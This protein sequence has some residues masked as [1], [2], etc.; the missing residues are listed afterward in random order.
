[1]LKRKQLAKMI[2]EEYIRFARNSNTNM[3]LF[4]TFVMCV[5]TTQDNL[6]F[7]IIRIHV[8]VQQLLPQ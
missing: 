2:K 1:M 3:T 5:G 7:S 4:L 8:Q 6:N